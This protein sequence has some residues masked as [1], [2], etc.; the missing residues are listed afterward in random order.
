[1][2]K[3]KF[4]ESILK[5]TCVVTLA[6]FLVPTIGYAE[7]SG[8]ETIGQYKCDFYG[9]MGDV[10]TGVLDSVDVLAKT[11]EDAMV[12]GEKAFTVDS[13]RPGVSCELI[14]TFK[15]HSSN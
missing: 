5:L 6:V 10:P 7:D 1:M 8:M 2:N 9:F 15:L 14:D 13:R 3:F 11:Y 12:L 4:Y